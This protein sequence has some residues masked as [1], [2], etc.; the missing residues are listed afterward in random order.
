MKKIL[1]LPFLGAL[2]LSVWQCANNPKPAAPT[3]Q[4]S[5]V[6]QTHKEAADTLL[7]D[8]TQPLKAIKY[9]ALDAVTARNLLTKHR[10]DSLFLVDYP[11]NGFYG[12]DRYRI[13]FIFTEMTADKNDPFLYH[14]KGKNRYKKEISTFEG[15]VKIDKISSFTDPN[16][17]KAEI[18]AMDIK[19][20]YTA[21]G[22]FELKEDPNLSSSGVFSGKLLLDFSTLK[23]MDRPELWFFSQSLKSGN[24]GYRFDGN[25]VSNKKKDM[26]KPV[27][28][29]QDLFRIGNDILKDF[30]YGER[31]VEVNPKY[32]DLGWA[33]FW[34]NEEWW[35]D[36][37]KPTM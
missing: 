12:T 21:E 4:K 35:R 7:A 28:W 1:L 11:C 16:L 13:E 8:S 9:A 5:V 2:T 25:W 31:E 30:S 6:L 23:T 17:D 33:D 3:I 18:E 22:T 24:C 32:R 26:V 14:V 20:A 37:K 36:A 27:I 10:I 29:S 34:E 15:T 19:N